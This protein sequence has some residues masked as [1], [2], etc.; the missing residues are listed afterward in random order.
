MLQIGDTLISLDVIEKEFVCDIPKCLGKCCEHGDSGAPL[1]K[2]EARL[3]KKEYPKI[4]PYLSEAGI[5]SIDKI[6][7]STIDKDG[8]LGTP[9][10]NNRECAY[11]VYKDGI[12]TCG[13]ENAWKE[14]KTTF[15]KPISC[16]L[17]PVRLKQY[18]T[19]LAVNYDH[20]DICKPA[21]ELGKKE[22]VPVYRFLKIPLIQR[23][24]Q[25]WY[26]ELEMAAEALKE[27]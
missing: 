17:Y 10:I 15:Q 27:Q 25:D 5:R 9:L 6:G 22:G 26:D 18:P 14:G 16:Y 3:L 4:E 20:W 23:F 8:D 19:F 2:K 1:E 12:A 13:I 11:T 21:L 7:T 24:G